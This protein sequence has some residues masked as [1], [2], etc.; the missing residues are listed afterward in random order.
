MLARQ[1]GRLMIASKVPILF[2]FGL[3]MLLFGCS[4]YQWGP[5]SATLPYQS[6]QVDPVIN[7]TNLPQV[8]LLTANALARSL[9]RSGPVQVNPPDGLPDAHLTV[10]LTNYRRDP[11]VP[12]PGVTGRARLF[13]VVLEAEASLIPA[14]GQNPYFQNRPFSATVEIPAE[15]DF[16]AAERAASHSLAEQLTEKISQAILYPWP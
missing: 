3:I 5:E 7:R 15:G 11:V 12:Q 9:T 16:A 4:S 10:V 13:Q 2:G 8:E 1:P 6:I 14:S